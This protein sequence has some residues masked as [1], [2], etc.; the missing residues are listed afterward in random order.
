MSTHLSTAN[1]PVTIFESSKAWRVPFEVVAGHMACR[2]S[3]DKNTFALWVENKFKSSIVLLQLRQKIVESH[4]Y[5]YLSGYLGA[6]F[7]AWA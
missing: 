6:F 3:I 4:V 7:S 1:V 5:F 2:R